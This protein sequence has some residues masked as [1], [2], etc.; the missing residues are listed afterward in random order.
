MIPLHGSMARVRENFAL[1]FTPDGL[2]YLY[3]RSGRGPAIRVMAEERDQMVAEFNRGLLALFWVFLFATIL[4]LLSFELWPDLLPPVL[5]SSQ[6]GV[7]AVLV[8]A[9]FMIGWWRLTTIAERQVGH[10]TPV[11]PG[12]TR[13][14]QHRF[15]LAR[16][17]WGVLALGGATT[18][19]LIAVTL[20]QPGPV[21][22]GYIAGGIVGTLFFAAL[23]WIKWRLR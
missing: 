10:R 12:L 11:A 14:E 8:L 19:T 15:N 2:G 5:G 20:R 6:Q 13:A 23:G 3:R 4:L 22:W 7:V 9:G 18:L 17:G 16:L 21:E 1:Q